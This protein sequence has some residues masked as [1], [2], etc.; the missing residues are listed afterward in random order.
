MR[1]FSSSFFR[2]HQ[3][4][5]V[6][7]SIIPN[8]P[9]YFSG[10]CV[11]FPKI[12]IATKLFSGEKWEKIWRFQAAQLVSGF[13]VK[14]AACLLVLTTMIVTSFASFCFPI[15]SDDDTIIWDLERCGWTILGIPRELFQREREKSSVYFCRKKIYP[16]IIFL[17]CRYQIHQISYI[18]QRCKILLLELNTDGWNEFYNRSWCNFL[19]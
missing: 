5:S 4:F 12:Q 9:E 8:F 2:S 1:T 13:F 19:F 3:Y 14:R 16:I 7:L 6:F 15:K 18:S 17:I 10:V 11:F